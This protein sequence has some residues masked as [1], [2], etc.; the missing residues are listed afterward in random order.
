MPAR[1]KLHLSVGKSINKSCTTLSSQLG[2]FLWNVT[3]G[4][5]RR[6]FNFINIVLLKSDTCKLWL[7]HYWLLLAVLSILYPCERLWCT[8]FSQ[9]LHT[10]PINCPKVGHNIDGCT[11]VFFAWIISTC[12]IKAQFVVF[13]KKRWCISSILW[14]SKS[15]VSSVKKANLNYI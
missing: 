10:I 3:M 4:Y 1:T 5:I 2:I 7:T 15:W 8:V 6:F 12:S 11:T 13:Q 14:P 9:P